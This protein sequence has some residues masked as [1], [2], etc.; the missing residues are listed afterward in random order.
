MNIGDVV[1][2]KSMG[3][4]PLVVIK[5]TED[6]H[7]VVRYGTQGQEG[8]R[9]IDEL[10]QSAELETPVESIEREGEI[11]RT[12]N[13]KKKEIETEI[14]EPTGKLIPIN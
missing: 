7:I 10:F 9:F 3:G 1:V 8:V 13:T 14:H 12:L 4:Q 11:F 5:L 6:G 2:H